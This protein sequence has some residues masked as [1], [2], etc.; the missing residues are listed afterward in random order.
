MRAYYS[1]YV[2]H[3]MRFFLKNPNV[4]EFQSKPDEYN[5]KVSR[6]IYTSLNQEDR[7]IINRFYLEKFADDWETIIRFEKAWARKRGLI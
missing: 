5:W 4:T 3:G 7:K 1:D 2:S 6:I